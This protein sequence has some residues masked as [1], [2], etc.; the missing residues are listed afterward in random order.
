MADPNY[1]L[2]KH[3]RREVYK[4]AAQRYVSVSFEQP[5]TT[6]EI[7]GRVPTTTL[8]QLCEMMMVADIRRIES[9]VSF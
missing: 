2:F 7:T 5:I 4:L 3:K 8:E 1:L 6:A 9:G